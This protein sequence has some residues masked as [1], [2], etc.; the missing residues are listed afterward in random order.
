MDTVA[1]RFRLYQAR[2]AIRA[3]NYCIMENAC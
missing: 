2:L 3:M 1:L